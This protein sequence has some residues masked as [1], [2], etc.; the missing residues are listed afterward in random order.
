[1]EFGISPERFRG[2]SYNQLPTFAFSIRCVLDKIEVIRQNMK[3]FRRVLGLLESPRAGIAVRWFVDHFA[4]VTRMTEQKNGM[5]T[6]RWCLD[7]H[8]VIERVRCTIEDKP[9]IGTN[10]ES[11]DENADE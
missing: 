7:N 11:S 3:M 8:D 1:M 9:H 6:L 10:H 5:E 2:I 4:L